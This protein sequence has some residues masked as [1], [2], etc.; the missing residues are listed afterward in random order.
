[1]DDSIIRKQIITMFYRQLL[2][3]EPDKPGLDFYMNETI[4]LGVVYSSLYS[5][6]EAK[7]L[8]KKSLEE[9]SNNENDKFP[10]TL[11]VFVK[12]AEDSIS[13]TIN[14]VKSVVKE[15][16]VLDTGSTDNTVEVCR[17]LG[18]LVYKCGFTNFG[19]IRTLAARLARQDFVLG[20]D[21]DETILEEDLPKFKDVIET[22]ERDGLDILGLP[23]KRWADLGMTKQLEKD[24]FPDWQY[25]FFRNIPKI[26]YVRRVHEIIKGSDRII[27]MEDGPCIQHFQDAFKSGKK[28][29]DRNDHYKSLYEKDVKEGVEHEEKAVEDLDER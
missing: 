10:I 15:I 9:K 14:S 19:D 13:L 8:E 3:R 16:V 18:A 1:M 26:H 23:R 12:D 2:G 4:P 29:K 20:L 22:M 11:A 17:D 27:D 25:R 7:E 5:S 6:D 21:S 24:V 28:L